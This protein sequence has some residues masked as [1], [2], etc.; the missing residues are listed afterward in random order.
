MSFRR[1]ASLVVLVIVSS[2]IVYGADTFSHGAQGFIISAPVAKWCGASNRTAVDVG[3]VGAAL[4]MLPDIAGNVGYY[5][6][7]DNGAAYRAWHSGKLAVAFLPPIGLHVAVDRAFHVDTSSPW[8][9][10]AWK[11]EIFCVVLEVACL[12]LIKKYVL[13]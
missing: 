11:Y 7:H 5:V 1:L 13:S 8:K 9:P 6:F 3:I 2:V 12:Y 4:G 10:N